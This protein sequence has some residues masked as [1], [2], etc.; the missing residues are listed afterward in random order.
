MLDMVENIRNVPDEAR[1][2]SYLA[3]AFCTV[4]ARL[5]PGYPDDPRAVHMARF[6]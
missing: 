6:V 1:S 2:R 3:T 4:T 5:E